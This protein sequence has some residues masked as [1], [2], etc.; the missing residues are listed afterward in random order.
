MKNYF[1]FVTVF[2]CSTL[3]ISFAQSNKIKNSSIITKEEKVYEFSIIWKE[4]SYNFDNFD[5]CP[6]L[7]IDSLYKAY[8]PLIQETKNDLEYFKLIQ[9][10]LAH[11]NNAHT[12]LYDWPEYLDPY[13]A[14]LYLKS[15]YKDGKIYVDNI[16]AYHKKKIYIGDEIVTVNGVDAVEY[17]KKY[18]VPYYS[19][20]NEEEK[21][22]YSMFARGIAH[23]YPFHTKFILGIKRDDEIKKVKIYTDRKL[24]NAPADWLVKDFSSYKENLFA[25]DTVHDFAYIRLISSKS[26]SENFFLQ[27]IDSIKRFN[28]LIL[29]IADNLGG[30]SKYNK[31]IYSYLIDK[32]TIMG[33]HRSSRIHIPYHKAKGCIYCN[34]LVRGD[35]WN[36]YNCNW[37]QGKQFQAIDNYNVINLVESEQRYKGKVYVMIG[38]NTASAGEDLAITLSQDENIFFIGKKTNGATGQTYLVSLPS[39]VKIGINTAKTYDFRDKDVSSGF[40]PN[41]ECDFSDIYKTSDIKELL[42]RFRELIFK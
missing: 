21:L 32:D 9:R 3:Q 17:F 22:S 8:L 12:F 26:N 1:L 31:F 25:V 42:F 39:G 28:H 29:D 24:N 14:L 40:L 37:C 18:Y 20:S 41:Y 10:F 33:Y 27:H 7:N 35:E 15:A 2:F 34:S 13:L 5:N 6:N 38:V 4:I 36:D 16:P 11:F 23:I 19:L 30:E